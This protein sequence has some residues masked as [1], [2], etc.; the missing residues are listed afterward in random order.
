MRKVLVVGAGITGL[1]AAYRLSK[2]GLDADITVLDEGD[3]P[4]G[5]IRTDREK[6]L[7]F[8]CGPD[9]FLTQKPQALEL[10][11]EL[12]LEAKLLNTSREETDV[13]VFV[14]GRLRRLPEG[15]LLMAPAKVLPFL[16]SDLLSWRGKLRMGL[17][18]VLPSFGDEDVS[19]G[20]FARRRFGR[21]AVRAI[22]QPIMAGI[23]AGDADEIS[24]KSTFPRFMDLER[25]HGSV[26][27]GLRAT[28]SGRAKD[29]DAPTAFVTLAGGLAELTDALARALPKGALRLG[30]KVTRIFPHGRGYRAMLGD[31]ASMDADAVVVTAPAWRAAEL[32]RVMDPELGSALMGIPFTSSAT[33][34]LLFDEGELGLPK[35]FGFVVARGE[36]RI[37]AAGTFTGSKFPGRVPQGS[38]VLRLFLGGAGREGALEQPDAT[39]IA[40]ARADLERLLGVGLGRRP[41]FVKLHRWPKG[42]PQY[43]VGHELRLRRIAARAAQHP[44][45]ELAGASYGGIGIPD[46]V[47]SGARAADSL[48]NLWTRP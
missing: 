1:S 23:Y 20:D 24:L 21:E 8:E 47:A 10:V 26:I 44:G 28:A 2:K 34:S 18:L 41:A 32:L 14:R 6:S 27:R 15:L 38:T 13:H 9:S 11:R 39:V 36:S 37:V 46:C 22:V 42:N 19:M 45:L 33:L 35:G 48:Y 7:T 31:D 29:P 3:R 25:E 4:G 5:K 17:D 43:V 12:G 30:A 16:K 40:A